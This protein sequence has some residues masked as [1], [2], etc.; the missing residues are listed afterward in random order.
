MNIESLQAWLASE[1]GNLPATEGAIF[2]LP[3]SNYLLCTDRPIIRI[4]NDGVVREIDC[5]LAEEDEIIRK[6]NPVDFAR[7][8]DGK[9]TIFIWYRNPRDYIEV[10][11][12][13]RQTL[14]DKSAYDLREKY[15]QDTGFMKLFPRRKK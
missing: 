5:D 1:M 15:R 8:P 14:E 7:Q 3:A 4:A 9:S 2:G 6:T 11:R 13:H 12:K 10:F